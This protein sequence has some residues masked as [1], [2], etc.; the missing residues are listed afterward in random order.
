MPKD[1]KQI[2]LIQAFIPIAAL[3]LIL[4]YNVFFV[5]GDDALS[6]SNQFVLLIGSAI[7]ASIGFINKVPFEKIFNQCAINPTNGWSS[8]RNM[9][10]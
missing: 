8:F 5:Y 6:G 1:S 2:S 9:V 10:S 7:A 3:V 4:F